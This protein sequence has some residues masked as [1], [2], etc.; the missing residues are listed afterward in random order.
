MR[1]LPHLLLFAFLLIAVSPWSLT[2]APAPIPSCET[3]CCMV[4]DQDQENEDGCTPGLCNP[5]QCAFCCFVCP[6]GNEKIEIR[7]YDSRLAVPGGKDDLQV[8]GHLSTCWQPPE[9]T[10]KT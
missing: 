10:W 7:V 8:T 4:N 2:L 5:A 6:L 1:G 3:E 9:W